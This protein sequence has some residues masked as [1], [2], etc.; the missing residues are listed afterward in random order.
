M[1]AARGQ[2]Y[3]WAMVLS[4]PVGRLGVV[5]A[6]NAGALGQLMHAWTDITVDHITPVL[7]E[8]DVIK[9]LS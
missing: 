1:G 2:N 4:Y 3:C 9:L 5:E 6:E 8:E 7:S